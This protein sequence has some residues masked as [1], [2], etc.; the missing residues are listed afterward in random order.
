MKPLKIAVEES[1]AVLKPVDE[2]DIEADLIKQK[3]KLK[4]WKIWDIAVRRN[5]LGIDKQSMMSGINRSI[6]RFFR[7]NNNNK[8]FSEDAANNIASFLN[9]LELEKY[10]YANPC[11]RRTQRAEI[12]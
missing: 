4:Y 12:R 7:I 10:D 9:G 6:I 8:V 1:S 11:L 5:R 2:T 3:E